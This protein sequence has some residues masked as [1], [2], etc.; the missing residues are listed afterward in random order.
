[1]TEN[2]SSITAL[3]RSSDLSGAP[4]DLANECIDCANLRFTIL[5]FGM[6]EATIKA[7][8]VVELN[9]TA[10]MPDDGALARAIGDLS[11]IREELRT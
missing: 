2:H 11:G 10:K 1:M 6:R 3:G 4:Y 9:V 7:K 8:A 5:A